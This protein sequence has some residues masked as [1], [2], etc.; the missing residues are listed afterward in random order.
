MKLIKFI[1]D[2]WKHTYFYQQAKKSNMK[3][4][5]DN[6]R[7]NHFCKTYIDWEHFKKTGQIKNIPVGAIVVKDL[8]IHI[9]CSKHIYVKDGKSEIFGRKMI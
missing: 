4:V 7:A 6:W 5:V 1:D 8:G 9:G 2:L 3:T